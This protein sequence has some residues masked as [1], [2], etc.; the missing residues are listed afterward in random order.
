M[1]GCV[2][3]LIIPLIATIVWVFFAHD[4]STYEECYDGCEKRGGS[5]YYCHKKSGLDYCS[6]SLNVD[7]YGKTCKTGHSCAK[8][9]HGYYWCYNNAGSWGYCS[10]VEKRLT[11]YTS[12]TY[13][14][15]CLDDCTD[16]VYANVYANV[17]AKSYFYC[18]TS[19]S[20]EW[21]YCSPVAH[22][23]YKNEV[24][25]A[26]DTCDLHGENYYWCKIGNS[27]NYCGLVEWDQCQPQYKAPGKRALLLLPGEERRNCTFDEG[28]MIEVNYILTPNRA[29]ATDQLQRS[30]CASAQRVI[31]QYSNDMLPSGPGELAS[32]EHWRLDMQ[33]ITT[34]NEHDQQH[35]NLQ[36]Q[37]NVNRRNAA[38][39]TTYATVL[40]P[41]RD[42]TCDNYTGQRRIRNALLTSLDERRQI[43]IEVRN[44]TKRLHG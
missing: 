25:N 29:M 33:G 6:P 42:F 28:N 38:H 2:C 35:Y 5:Y 11:R 27:W 12:S 18:I 36:L 15:L 10:P 37:S 32:N 21:D 34:P 44:K 9:G 30:R 26:D 23:S 20:G 1:R 31:A 3:F 43:R 40:V 41:H 22:V 19:T 13:K 16:Y 7:Y 8:H 14:K 39:R 4:S 17:Y 24:C